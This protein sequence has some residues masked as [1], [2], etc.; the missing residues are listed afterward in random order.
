M[1]WQCKTGVWLRALGNGDQRRPMSRKAREG[2]Y[3][4]VRYVDRTSVHFS[5]WIRRNLCTTSHRFFPV[6]Q[7]FPLLSCFWCVV[8]KYIP[9]W[10]DSESPLDNG[11]HVNASL[12]HRLHKYC[13]FFLFKN[14]IIQLCHQNLAIVK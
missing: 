1:V 2:L 10:Y 7:R 3:V 12:F 4:Y 11:R 9:M 5:G 14:V 6:M 13:N 8:L